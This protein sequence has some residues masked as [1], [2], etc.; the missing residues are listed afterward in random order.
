MEIVSLAV[1]KTCLFSVAFSVCITV[2]AGI[3]GTTA[4]Y[5]HILLT[6]LINILGEICAKSVR[7]E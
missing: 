7:D 6:V 5:I 2:L 4:E 3:T 1:M